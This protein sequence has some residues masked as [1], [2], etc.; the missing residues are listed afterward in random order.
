MAVR[1][2]IQLGEKGGDLILKTFQRINTQKEKFIKPATT[3]IGTK[4][5]APGV[6]G[7]EKETTKQQTELSQK[8][9][10]AA[11]ELNALANS[12]ASLNP[13]ALISGAIDSVTRVTEHLSQAVPY[14]GQAL[15]ATADMAANSLSAIKN[16][17][18]SA[19]DTLQKQGRNE[20][21]GGGTFKGNQNYS[22]SEQSNMIEAI[23]AK[24]GKF[25]Q[26]KD[27]VNAINNLYKN[28]PDI[29]Q[30][31][32]VAS[33]NYAALGTDKGYFMQQI[34]DSM[35]NLPPS[36]MQSIQAQLLPM[37]EQE[38]NKDKAQKYRSQNAIVETAAQKTQIQTADMFNANTVKMNDA[39]NQMTID[40][41]KTGS[42]LINVFAKITDAANGSINTLNNIS[43]AGKNVSSFFHNLFGVSKGKQ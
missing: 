24:F 30:A 18:L 1:E 27:L 37:A 39:F 29:Q 42:Q 14:I 10:K 3:K 13:Q 5:S 34:M 28:N 9:G 40:L 16:A 2:I 33:G 4:I 7:Q 15:S 17:Q 20:Y 8:A 11:N 32:A 26:N 38:L 21:F 23:S 25:G 19:M 35:G 41:T 12:A 31:T 22:L 43:N 6:P 36:M